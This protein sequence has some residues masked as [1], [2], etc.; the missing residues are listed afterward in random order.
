MNIKYIRSLTSFSSNT[1]FYRFIEYFLNSADTQ[2]QQLSTGNQT[3]KLPF[4]QNV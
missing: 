3:K 1:Q 2:Q 4:L